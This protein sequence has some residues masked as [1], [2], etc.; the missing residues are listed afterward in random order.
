[1]KVVSIQTYQGHYVPDKAYKVGP[2]FD[3][4][5]LRQAPV[6]V[7]YS[8]APEG[9]IAF[10]AGATVLNNM[11]GIKYFRCTVCEDVVA[12]DDLNHHVCEVY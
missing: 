8:L 1:M 9:D 7:D 12:E 4:E 2:I 10:P 11:Q 6:D 5:V 3:S